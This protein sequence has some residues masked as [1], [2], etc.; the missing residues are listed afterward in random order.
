MVKTILTTALLTTFI[1]S[2]LAAVQYTTPD[3]WECDAPGTEGYF[4][5][6]NAVTY[7]GA[8][9]ACVASNGYL[10]DITNQNFLFSTDLVRK[11][12]G[13]NQNAWIR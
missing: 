6:N 13:D 7:D 10:A 2:A 3:V 11:C 4:I 5:S 9:D 1:S 8:A 12:V